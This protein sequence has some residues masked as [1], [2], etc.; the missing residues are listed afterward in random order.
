MEKDMHCICISVTLS[1]T[2]GCGNFQTRR[3]LP[4]VQSHSQLH[5]LLLVGGNLPFFSTSV[6]S[7]PQEYLIM[8]SSECKLTFSPSSFF[9][10]PQNLSVMKMTEIRSQKSCR[11]MKDQ[12]LQLV[13]SETVTILSLWQGSSGGKSYLA[14]HLEWKAWMSTLNLFL[15]CLLLETF[16][17]SLLLL[18]TLSHFFSD[19]LT[20]GK[21]CIE[22]AKQ[23]IYKSVP[24]FLKY[25][26]TIN[27]NW[28][29]FLQSSCEDLKK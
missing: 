15:T 11:T 21:E 9:F 4:L 14:Y 19:L 10:S 23:A 3:Q 24:V 18:T 25:I 16:S 20:K 17:L 27:H 6:I 8:T 2:E 12:V 13:N 7:S 26:C 1:M 28:T 5:T 22:P 29:Y